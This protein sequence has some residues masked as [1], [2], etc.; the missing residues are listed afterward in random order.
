[1]I[2]TYP[3]FSQT[4]VCMAET[5]GRLGRTEDARRSLQEARS[6]A[7]TFFD[8]CVRNRPPRSGQANYDHVMEG[9]RKAG[10][11]DERGYRGS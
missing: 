8:F 2:Q 10:W 4:H 5:Q 3:D 9:L 11:Q 6:I 7:R 1:V